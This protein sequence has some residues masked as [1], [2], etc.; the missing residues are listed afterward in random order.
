MIENLFDLLKLNEWYFIM[1]EFNNFHK[2]CTNILIQ[3]DESESYKNSSWNSSYAERFLQ[4]GNSEIFFTDKYESRIYFKV[5]TVVPFY[6]LF[7]HFIMW[8]IR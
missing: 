4:I 7:F 5:S 1:A 8:L 3:W 2:F 6:H